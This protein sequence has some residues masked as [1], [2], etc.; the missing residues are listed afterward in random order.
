MLDNEGILLQYLNDAE[1][2]MRLTYKT[3][4]PLSTAS[5]FKIGGPASYAVFPQN[6][7]EMASL[8]SLCRSISVPFIV[9]GNGSNLLFDDSGYEG[10]VI[11]TGELKTISI[12]GTTVFAECGVSLT[13][14]SSVCGKEGLSGLEF[15]YGIPGSLGGAV[16]MNAGAYGGEMKDV[17]VS[18]DYYDLDS[19]ELGSFECEECAFEY[20][21]SIFNRSNKI[22]LSATLSLV[23]ADKDEIKRQMDEYMTSRK[24]KQPLNF[25]SAGSTFK[26]YPG[27]FTAKLIDEAS[28]KGFS[29]GGA[30]VSPKH[31]GFVVNTGN[32]TSD[33]VKALIEHIKAVIKEK[34]GI[35]IEC[36]VKFISDP[37]GKV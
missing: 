31:A 13:H 16:Y 3:E 37:K 23:C 24:E 15:A 7:D 30:Q 36:E 27:Y 25:P 1:K 12:D 21:G 8:C 35:D 6:V 2:D 29:V 17:I 14:L 20:R 10:V 26:R 28:L 33:D 4:Y 19:D 18:V 34:V 11:F 22:I 32:A 9:I 5:T